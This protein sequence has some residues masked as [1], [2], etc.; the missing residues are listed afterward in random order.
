MN[1]QK[2]TKHNF[3]LKID[4]SIQLRYGN[5]QT[6]KNCNTIYTFLMVLRVYGCVRRQRQLNRDHYMKSTFFFQFLFLLCSTVFITYMTQKILN[7]MLAND[8]IAI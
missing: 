3:K 8:C 5:K 1:K 6:N 7:Q 2:Q 4:T